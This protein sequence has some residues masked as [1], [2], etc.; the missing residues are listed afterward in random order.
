MDVGG[1]VGFEVFNTKCHNA[2]TSSIYCFRDLLVVSCMLSLF[3]IFFFV[4]C[5]KNILFL[6][7]SDL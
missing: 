4:I 5:C 2:R 7:V 1:S 3:E 6:N